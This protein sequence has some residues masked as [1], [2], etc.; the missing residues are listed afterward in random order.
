M[1]NRKHTGS[2][3]TGL[4]IFVLLIAIGNFLRPDSQPIDQATQH[5][6]RQVALASVNAERKAQGIEK[7]VVAD[8]VLQNWLDGQPE[9]LVSKA[10][11]ISPGTFLEKLPS[12]KLTLSHASLYCISAKSPGSLAGQLDLW[13]AAFK[14]STN[15]VAMRLYR[16]SK[17]KIG[18]LLIAAKKVPKFNLALFNN[19]HSEFY[20]TCRNCNKSHVGK[21]DKCDLAIA[22]QCS[23]CN[24]SYDLIAADMLGNYHRANQYLHGYRPPPEIGS[25]A[26][27][28]VEELTAIWAA[29]VARCRYSKDLTGLAGRKDSWQ[30]PSDTYSFRN[31]DCE[32][33][34]LLLVDWL[35]SRGFNSRVVIGHTPGKGEHAWCVTELEGR[36]YL[37]ET[38]LEKIPSNPPQTQ[39]EASRY[40]PRFSFD[41]QNIYFINGATRNVSDYFSPDLWKAFSYPSSAITRAPSVA[42]HPLQTSELQTNP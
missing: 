22:L 28:R 40:L 2:L 3:L 15:I 27:T 9:S 23:H 37:L 4:M 38:T 31:G 42:M 20:V 32:D 19:G 12:K 8:S 41:R 36:Q 5:R 21:L 39:L 7:A 30:T 14:A 13:K 1:L 24:H 33:T 18:C 17:S 26:L 34:S 29:V 6:F 10:A 11:E 25:G 16:S 35:I